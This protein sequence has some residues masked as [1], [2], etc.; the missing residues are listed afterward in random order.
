MRSDNCTLLVFN[1]IRQA[2]QPA[3]IWKSGTLTKRQVK[4]A[5]KKLRRAGFIERISYGVWKVLVPELPEKRRDKTAPIAPHVALT[6]PHKEGTIPDTVRAH[7]MVLTLRIPKLQAWDRREEI[8]SMQDKDGQPIMHFK[9]IPQGQRI[10]FEGRKIWLCDRSIVIYF[11]KEYS[12]F[13]VTAPEARQA[14]LYET[15]SLIKKLEGELHVGQPG[16]RIG[17]GYKL[18]FSRNH[19][20]LIKNALAAQYLDEK[21]KLFVYDDDGLWLTID[22]SFNLLETETLHPATAMDDNVKVQN[23]FNGIKHTGITPEFILEGLNKCQGL[24]TQQAEKV[25]AEAAA[26]LQHFEQ[27]VLYAEQINAHLP[28]LKGLGPALPALTS[29]LEVLGPALKN[30][31]ALTQELHAW[32]GRRPRAQGKAR[33]TGIPSK[34]QRNLKEFA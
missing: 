28:V 27:T 1:S 18:H 33:N 16:F 23:F 11:P 5:L 19:Y 34:G 31:Q 4:Y 10:F 12:W 2:I 32:L 3:E 7:G 29:A 20:S 30:L 17:K 14:V 8:L 25:T 22:N 21:K 13:K 6:H 15:I 9:R 26:N 24:I